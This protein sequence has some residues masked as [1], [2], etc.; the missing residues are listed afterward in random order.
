MTLPRKV[1]SDQ[2]VAVVAEIA[3]E[4][5]EGVS[6]DLTDPDG[7]DPHSRVGIEPPHDHALV[8]GAGEQARVFDSAIKI[9]K[10][11]LI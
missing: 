5:A 1:I 3:T 2:R 8:K 11:D 7:L 6:A 9:K 10:T 4:E